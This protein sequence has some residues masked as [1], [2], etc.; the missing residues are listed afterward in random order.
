MHADEGTST[1]PMLESILPTGTQVNEEIRKDTTKKNEE[2]PQPQLTPPQEV[3]D[4]NTITDDSANRNEDTPQPQLSPINEATD[5]KTICMTITD[6]DSPEISKP[7]PKVKQTVSCNGTNKPKQLNRKELRWMENL[8]KLR[9]YKEEFG[10]CI[11]PRGYSDD[12][13]L[14]S[15]VRLV[16]VIEPC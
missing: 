3:T 1:K 12:P 5:V 15:W 7:R 13:R 10:D 16:R 6:E 11:V 4:A 8:E 2:T 9:A 14:A